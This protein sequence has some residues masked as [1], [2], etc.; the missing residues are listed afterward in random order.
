MESQRSTKL[1]LLLI[2]AL[3]PMSLAS[4]ISTTANKSSAPFESTNH[5]SSATSSPVIAAL[6]AQLN[7]WRGTPYLLGG[8]NRR[9]I[10]CS[11]FVQ[12]TFAD[13]FERQL[14]RTTQLLAKQGRKI[15]S[16]ELQ[17]GDLVFFKT[18]RGVRHVGV[19][20]SEG[21]F[22]HASK[23]AGVTLSNIE[24]QYWKQHYWQSRRLP[25]Q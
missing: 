23:S 1:F 2:S 10:D 18:G 25:R 22:V 6:Y 12:R 3:I 4:C 14:P 7:E 21:N 24:N 16:N 5:S 9:G 13:R 17:A 8:N 20:I 19:F 11:G 15:A